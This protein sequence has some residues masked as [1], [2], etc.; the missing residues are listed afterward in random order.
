MSDIISLEAALARIAELEAAQ[1]A[2]EAPSDAVEV[3]IVDLD[4]DG[5]QMDVRAANFEP[6]VRGSALAKNPSVTGGKLK[7]THHAVDLPHAVKTIN[8]LV[9]HLGPVFKRPEARKWFF[10]A[11]RT[12]LGEYQRYTNEMSVNGHFSGVKARVEDEAPGLL[13]AKGKPETWTVDMFKLAELNKLF[14]IR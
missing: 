8:N 13:V 6:A 9:S 11:A 7:S 12:G 2:Q 14:N 10:N 5:V 1:A 3:S 4:I